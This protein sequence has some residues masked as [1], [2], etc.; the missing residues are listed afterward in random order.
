MGT[1]VLLARCRSCHDWRK[2]L[3]ARMDSPSI[4]NN[5][6]I[7]QP[8]SA[9]NHH[10]EGAYG[11]FQGGQS[12]PAVIRF[13]PERAR[14]IREQVWHPDQRLD[15]QPDGSLL[16]TVLVADLREIKLQVMQYGAEAE[17]L[18]PAALREEIRREV[19]KMARVYG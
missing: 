12:V 8:R 17:V 18:A 5:S 10:L 7:P 9:W 3:L 16:L 11:I 15:Q 19:E 4:T 13:A 1:W 6:F 2:F 14:R